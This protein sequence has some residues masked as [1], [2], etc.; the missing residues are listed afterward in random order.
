M[1]RFVPYLKIQ[2]DMFIQKAGTGFCIKSSLGWPSGSES[3]Q[4]VVGT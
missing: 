1:L 3:Q 2:L 4:S